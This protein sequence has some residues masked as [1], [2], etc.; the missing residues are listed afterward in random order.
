MNQSQLRRLTCVPL[1]LLLL[2]LCGCTSESRQGDI[3]VVHFQLWLPAMLFAIPVVVGAAGWAVRKQAKWGLGM[4]I[5]TSIATV[6]FAPNIF[7][8]EFVVGPTHITRS[9]GFWFFPNRQTVAFN[10]VASIH[11]YKSVTIGRRGRRSTHYTIG[12]KMK[13]GQSKS[14]N[15]GDLLEWH[16]LDAL[17]NGAR[18]HGV[19]IETAQLNQ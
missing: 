6:F 13:D 12:C 14:M 9:G 4:V 16:G 19:P 11:V 2:S 7:F 5:L 15:V 17:I 18:A 3:T 8:D 1:A 10:D